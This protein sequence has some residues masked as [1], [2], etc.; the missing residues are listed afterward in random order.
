MAVSASCHPIH[1]KTS[2]AYA[3]NECH[4]IGLIIKFSA[5]DAAAPGG[6]LYPFSPPC[7][8]IA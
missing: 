4:V 7:F 5:V 1:K 8:C 3:N 6:L 2:L